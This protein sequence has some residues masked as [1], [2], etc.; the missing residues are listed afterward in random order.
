MNEQDNQQPSSETHRVC[1][2]CGVKK[3]IEAFKKHSKKEYRRRSCHECDRIDFTA[4]HQ[5]WRDE[6]R[7]YVRDKSRINMS[8]WRANMTPEQKQAFDAKMAVKANVRRE[9]LRMVVYSGYGRVCACCG[10]DEL[11]FLSIDHVNND[12]YMRRKNGEGHGGEQ[13]FVKIVRENFPPDFQLLCM[14]CNHGKARNGGICPHVTSGKVQRLGHEPV[15]SSDAKPPALF[16][17]EVKI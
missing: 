12:G 16:C 7:T 17:E 6:N 2:K 4:V 11:L 5:K 3:P 10:E 8:N 13:L 1:R 14:N 15:A 9:R